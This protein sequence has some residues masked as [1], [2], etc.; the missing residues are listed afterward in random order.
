M[1]SPPSEPSP[2]KGEGPFTSPSEPAPGGREAA[3]TL[4]PVHAGLLA[5]HR[6][7]WLKGLKQA[8]RTR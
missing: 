6:A 8:R 4:R 7:V 2:I 3:L 1:L 5:K